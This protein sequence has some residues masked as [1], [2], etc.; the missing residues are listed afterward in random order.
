MSY[1]QPRANKTDEFSCFLWVVFR[2][3]K[4]A[5]QSSKLSQKTDRS[6]HSIH[7]YPNADACSMLPVLLHVLPPWPATW[8]P[9]VLYSTHYGFRETCFPQDH[10]CEPLA[11]A[12]TPFQEVVEALG[13]K[14]LLKEL[15][16][17]GRLGQFIDLLHIQ[18]SPSFLPPSLPDAVPPSPSTDPSPLEPHAKIDLPKQTCPYTALAMYQRNG[19]VTTDPWRSSLCWAFMT[20]HPAGSL[21]LSSASLVAWVTNMVPSKPGGKGLGIVFV[22]FFLD[23]PG[24]HV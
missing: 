4:R 5:C 10:K 14:V 6:P 3:T 11:C 8:R 1:A 23:L 13:S 15:T 18:F 24:T 12:V 19:I 2:N 17:W 9:L 7:H 20:Q 22:A 21:T 16:C